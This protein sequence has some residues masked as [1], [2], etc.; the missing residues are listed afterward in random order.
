MTVGFVHNRGGGNN[1]Y[2]A[3]NND[4]F[5]R[6]AEGILE[7]RLPTLVE[8]GYEVARSRGFDKTGRQLAEVYERA[9]RLH[10]KHLP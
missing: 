4:E 3:D 2:F 8:E 10:G 5:V 6:L 7:G 9:L 1:S